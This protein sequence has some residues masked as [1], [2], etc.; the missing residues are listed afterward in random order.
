[1]NDVQ[2]SSVSYFAA[3][4]IKHIIKETESISEPASKRNRYNTELIAEESSRNHKMKFLFSLHLSLSFF[5]SP[6]PWAARLPDMG[7]R[8]NTIPVLEVE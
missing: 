6:L 4:N 5:F 2:S 1:M 7:A 8:W 3:L